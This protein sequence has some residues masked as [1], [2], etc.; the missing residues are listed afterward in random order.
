MTLLCHGSYGL[1]TVK[2]GGIQIVA[3]FF[4]FLSLK[5]TRW[6][7]RPTVFLISLFLLFL[8]K[9][10]THCDLSL[11][12]SNW[13]IKKGAQTE[14]K[15]IQNSRRSEMKKTYKI[16]YIFIYIITWHIYV[17]HVWDSWGNYTRMFSISPSHMD[18]RLRKTVWANGARNTK[19]IYNY[20]GQ[21]RSLGARES[22]D[23]A[24]SIPPSPTFSYPIWKM[25]WEVNGWSG[26]TYRHTPS[27]HRSISKFIR[28]SHWARCVA[29]QNWWGEKAREDYRSFLS[30]TASSYPGAL[31]L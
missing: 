31:C 28:H 21:S 26:K 3:S 14:K 4:V 22:W 6:R 20:K 9:N 13:P 24:L 18:L 19:I 11:E 10:Q 25:A 7:E 8:S 27:P 15:R 1:H 17:Q 2:T 12:D 30:S 23:P 29:Y 16:I 5:M